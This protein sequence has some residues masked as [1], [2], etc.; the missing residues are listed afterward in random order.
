[1]PR[2]EERIN[3]EEENKGGYF[4]EDLFTISRSVSCN[5]LFGFF[6]VSGVSGVL[7]GLAGSSAGSSAGEDPGLFKGMLDRGPQNLNFQTQA[8]QVS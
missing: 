7:A 5:G 2:Y 6:V 3:V 1:M 4:E 8:S